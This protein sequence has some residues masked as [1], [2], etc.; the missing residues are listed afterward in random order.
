MV[1]NVYYVS[2][3]LIGYL[4]FSSIVFNTI[5]TL[6]LICLNYFL[7]HKFDE[8][9]VRHLP[10]YLTLIVFYELYSEFSEEFSSNLEYICFIGVI[11]VVSFIIAKVIITPKH[12]NLK[13]YSYNE[14]ILITILVL[15][16][17]AVYAQEGLRPIRNPLYSIDLIDFSPLLYTTVKTSAMIWL[18]TL[19]YILFVT[20]MFAM[21]SLY[22]SELKGVFEVHYTK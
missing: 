9:I 12:F 3:F 6:S 20:R 17:V 16:R 15:I 8:A 19:F 21:M 14:E 11:L 22:N 1:F 2:L 7:L 5:I 10:I 18:S 13:G 4:N